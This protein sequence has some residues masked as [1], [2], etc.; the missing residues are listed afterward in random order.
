MSRNELLEQALDLK[1]ND[2]FVLI[3]ELLKSLDKPD[4][5]IDKIWEDEAVTRLASY[6]SG[7]VEAISSNE[8]FKYEG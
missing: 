3:D 5:E 4:S 7:E 8:F 2:K 1:A 6:H